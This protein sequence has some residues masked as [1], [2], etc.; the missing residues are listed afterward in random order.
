MNTVTLVIDDS[1]TFQLIY[2][3]MKTLTCDIDDPHSS[4][5]RVQQSQDKDS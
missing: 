1:H 4:H 3:N 2:I 5:F